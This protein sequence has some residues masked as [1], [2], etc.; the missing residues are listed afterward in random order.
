MSW[1]KAYVN[2]KTTTDTSSLKVNT[3]IKYNQAQNKCNQKVFRYTK[4]FV[5]AEYQEAAYNCKHKYKY[6]H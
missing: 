3:E 2:R 4:M 1:S 6:I 5:V